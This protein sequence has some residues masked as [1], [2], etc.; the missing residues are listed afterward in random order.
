[1]HWEFY[2]IVRHCNYLIVWSTRMA[3]FWVDESRWNDSYLQ[4]IFLFFVLFSLRV[5]IVP[6]SIA[7]V[8]VCFIL[9]LN[10]ALL[11]WIVLLFK[12]VLHF[13]WK[14]DRIWTNFEELSLYW[15]DLYQSSSKFK[16][17]DFICF[18]V[19]DIIAVR[20]GNILIGFLMRTSQ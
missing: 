3:M 19:S 4:L 9:G 11:C 17:Y 15:R 14:N 16:R 5:L 10:I 20:F 7:A 6:V 2:H 12:V 13:T 8:L 1:M 18:C